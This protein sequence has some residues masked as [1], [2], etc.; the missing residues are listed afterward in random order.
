MA[1][2]LAASA[3]PSAGSAGSTLATIVGNRW[4][5]RPC[6]YRTPLHYFDMTAPQTSDPSSFP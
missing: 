6:G 1:S 3:D 2:R 4:Q 5:A